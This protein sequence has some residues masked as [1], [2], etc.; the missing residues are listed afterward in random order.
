MDIFGNKIKIKSKIVFKE[1]KT[2]LHFFYE[3]V[4]LASTNASE[5]SV[6]IFFM[7]YVLR[8]AKVRAKQSGY[9]PKIKSKEEADLIEAAHKLA[10]SV[11]KNL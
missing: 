2:L 3:V 8:T 7:E 4:A 11:R 6:E 10:E 1:Y 5:S 9:V